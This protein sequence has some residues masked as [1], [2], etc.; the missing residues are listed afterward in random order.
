MSND[1]PVSDNFTPVP[2]VKYED[3][4]AAP[5][6]PVEPTEPKVEEPKV[7]PAPEPT[8]EPQT[9]EPVKPEP[10]VERPKKAGPIAKLLEDRHSL[11]EENA[12]LKRKLEEASQQPASPQ[13]T[14]D[15]KQLADEFGLDETLLQRIVDTARGSAKPELPKEV[16]D[17]LADHQ[18]GRQQQEEEAQF[19]ADYDSLARTFESEPL[20]D[21]SVKDKVL[22]LAYSTEKAPDGVP[23]YQKPLHELYFKFVKPEIEPGKPS[24]ESSQGGSQATKVID[25]EEIYN[26]DD[27]KELDAMDSDTF[28]KYNTWVKEHKETK[29]PITRIG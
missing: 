15:V 22:D 10:V 23:Y 13:A 1:I 5:A 29:T 2:G 24:A 18:R 28:T 16:Q 9:Q 26:R 17:L 11:E 7:E 25:F 8:V 6:A 3:T 14:A 21:Q 19:N 12:E 27:P 20:K 4:P